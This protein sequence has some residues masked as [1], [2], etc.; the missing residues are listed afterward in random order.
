MHMD[1]P[2]TSGT[3]VSTLVGASNSS[4]IVIYYLGCDVTSILI[5]HYVSD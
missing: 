5:M 2:N 3:L 4:A 1:T